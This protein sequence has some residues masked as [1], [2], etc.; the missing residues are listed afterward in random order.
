MILH[1]FLKNS[2][3]EI[4]KIGR[5]HTVPKNF[6]LYVWVP[7]YQVELEYLKLDWK[8][9]EGLVFFGQT[10]GHTNMPKSVQLVILTR[11]V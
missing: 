6:H 9:T 2:W 1:D 5:I 8:E 4:S 10:N 11:S 7:V 3:P